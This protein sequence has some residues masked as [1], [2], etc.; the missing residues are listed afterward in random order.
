MQSTIN[1][2]T[3]GRQVE[4][5]RAAAIQSDVNVIRVRVGARVVLRRGSLPRAPDLAVVDQLLDAVVARDRLQLNPGLEVNFS[6]MIEE[7]VL[8]AFSSDGVA[9]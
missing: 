8:T 7:G 4:V 5:L 2:I 1:R 3:L 9:K 6:K